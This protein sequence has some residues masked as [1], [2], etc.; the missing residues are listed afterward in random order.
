M[1]IS[2]NFPPYF[3]ENLDRLLKRRGLTHQEFADALNGKVSRSAISKWISNTSTPTLGNVQMIA[4]YFGLKTSDM[5]EDHGEE[6][7]YTD[8]DARQYADEIS[9]DKDLRL[10]L[11]AAR[12]VE[13]KDIRTVTEVLK[14]LK[15]KERGDLDD[16][17]Q[18]RPDDDDF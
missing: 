11:D 17:D 2:D 13:R 8:P 6:H 16:I 5:L 7:Y 9:K 18:R 1:T 14:S 3:G 12:D 15:R 10:L 4:E